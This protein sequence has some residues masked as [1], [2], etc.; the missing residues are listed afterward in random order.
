M[1]RNALLAILTVLDEWLDGRCDAVCLWRHR[2]E[3]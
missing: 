1:M 2:L 3:N